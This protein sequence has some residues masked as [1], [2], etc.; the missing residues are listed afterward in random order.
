MKKLYTLVI[1]AFCQTL[2]FGQQDKNISQWYHSN[3]LY[4]AGSVATGEED[5]GFFTNFRSQWL[6]IPQPGIG[7]RTN[8]LCAEFKVPDGFNG[9]NN[10]G[11]GIVAVNDQTGDARFMT[12]NVSVPINY[13]LQLD[14][15]NR[16]SIGI[17]PGFYQQ[18]INPDAQTWESQWNGINYVTRPNV[19]IGI[20][21]SYASIDLGAGLFYQHTTREKTRI[22]GGVALNHI[23]RQKINFSFGGDRIYMQTVVHGGADI[24]TNKK[25]LRIQPNVMFFRA[26]RAYNF[27]AGLTLEHILKNPSEITTINKTT[28]INYGFYYRHNDALVTSLGFKVKGV[29]FGLAFDANLSYLSQATSSVGAIEVYFKTM[30]LYRKSSTRTKLK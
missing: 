27:M 15:S 19:E 24:T 28:C 8:T 16:L 20:N 10:F 23:T 29:R 6:T 14:R 9:V 25:D 22:Y 26:G 1:F 18:S 4:N 21:P 2:A 11:V 13:S 30:H 12:T 7:M 17:S 5:F 3:V